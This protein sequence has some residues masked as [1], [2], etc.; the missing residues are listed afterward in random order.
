MRVSYALLDD[1]INAA[2]VDGIPAMRFPRRDTP[3]HGCAR[4]VVTRSNGVC[5]LGG[6]FLEIA[7]GGRYEWIC[8][9]HWQTRCAFVV[10][11]ASRRCL[12]VDGS[13]LRLKTHERGPPRIERHRVGTQDR[14]IDGDCTSR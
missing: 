10:E 1:L 2:Q 6:L 14:A 7:G 8:D 13:E 9:L 12:P 5:N 11:R 3:Q 4:L